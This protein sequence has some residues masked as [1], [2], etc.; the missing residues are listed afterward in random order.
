MESDTFLIHAPGEVPPVIKVWL[1]EDNG[2]FRRTLQRVLDGVEGL[3]CQKAFASC[4]S[5]LTTLASNDSN[6]A[7]A[8]EG[9]VGST[10]APPDCDEPDV[11]LMDVGLP[12]MSGLEGIR[13]VRA[14]RPALPVLVLTVFDDPEKIRQSVMAGAAGYLLK[15][16]S[17]EEIGAAI[18]QAYLGG[19]PM[20]AR[21]AG[22]VWGLFA[23]LIRPSK[24]HGLTERELEILR[25]L[26]QGLV[27][28]EIADRLQVS[29]HTVDAHLKHIF[30]KLGVH[31]SAAAVAKA[32]RDNLI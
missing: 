10:D 24:S 23:R 31:T 4:E 22:T 15:T 11:M 16:S 29:F 12:G 21:V 13:R 28:K 5:A 14:C 18:R 9:A 32:L 8:G 17:M 1:V 20:D 7:E 25:A 26:A 6:R 30:Q 3:H 27:K 19:T 2:A